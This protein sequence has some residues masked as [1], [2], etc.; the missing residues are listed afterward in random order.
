MQAQHAATLARAESE[1]H[2]QV[3]AVRAQLLESQTASQLL[4]QKADQQTVITAQQT[5]TAA[6]EVE[7]D[8]MKRHYQAMQQAFMQKVTSAHLSEC[9][10]CHSV[11][12]SQ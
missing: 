10:V 6:F 3:S 12:I 9:K 2:Q 11:C 4:T 7:K 1:A 5:L 8:Q